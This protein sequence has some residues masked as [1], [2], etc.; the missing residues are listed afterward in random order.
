MKINVKFAEVHTALFL[1]GVNLGLKL[2]PSKR[3]GLKLVWDREEKELI[4][5]YK[6]AFKVVPSANVVGWDPENAVDIGMQSALHMPTTSKTAT[7]PSHP[8]KANIKG[9]QVSTPQDHV[10]KT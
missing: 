8:M 10:F 2:D 6:N 9:A 5:E 1:N 3:E 7:H 4:I